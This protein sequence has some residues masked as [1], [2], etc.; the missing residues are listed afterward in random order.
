MI[1]GLNV[2]TENS[3]TLEANTGK[4]KISVILIYAKLS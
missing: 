4:K 1:I 3:K 2:E